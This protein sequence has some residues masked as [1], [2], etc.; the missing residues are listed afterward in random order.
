VKKRI[1]FVIFVVLLIGVGLLVYYGQWKT[2][3]SELSYS[4]TVE[5]TEA[6][7]AFQ[8]GG[9]VIN[10]PV[11]EGQAV[12]KDQ[13][14][15]ELDAAELQTRYDQA[16]AN[17][18]R[19]TKAKEQLETVLEIYNNTLP[20]DVKR[21]EA[22]TTLA[23]NVMLDARKNNERYE[24]LFKRGVV[25]ENE[26][27]SVRLGFDNAQS[28]LD[29][30]EAV[31]KQA[32]SNLK[33]IEATEKDIESAQAQINFARSALDQT[34][35]QLSYAQVHAP[36]RGVITSRNVEPGEVVT[37]GR[38][39]M[40][41]SDLSRVDLKIF[42][43]E[44]EIAKVK[45]GHKVEVMVDTFPGKVY[46]GTVS[47][48]SPEAEFTPKIIQTKKERVKLVY[49][50]KVSIDNPNMELKAGMPADAYLR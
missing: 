1:I 22:N 4:G 43:D 24:Q 6:N 21:A 14:L 50:V 5:A 42:V 18:D 20:A 30:S 25:S 31:L 33:K 49:L 27:D 45:P 17:V 29:E 34:G 15:A 26:R 47:Y 7:L 13:L 41:V 48:I 8:I 46:P 36:V 44:T 40:T 11:Q 10:V 37:P 28:R 38:E 39:I 2:K 16:K 9:R 23:R 3:H 32:K 12:V 19:A 35:V